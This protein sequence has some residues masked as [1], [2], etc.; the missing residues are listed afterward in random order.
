MTLAADALSALRAITSVCAA[1]AGRSNP[2]QC[3][4]GVALANQLRDLC[5]RP[6]ANADRNVSGSGPPSLRNL[7]IELL[8]QVIRH[9][10]V[11]SLARLASTCRQLYFGP[12]CPPWPTSV[13]EEELRRRAAAAGK[14]LPSSPP[15]GASRW[16]PALLQREWRD[17]LQ[18]CTVAAG[19]SPHSLF[20]D[21]NGALVVCGFEEELGTLGLPR[22]QGANQSHQFCTVLLP[23]PVPSM[24]GIRIWQVVASY[25]CSLALSEAVGY[26]CGGRVCG[27]DLRRTRKTGLC[28][29]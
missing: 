11:R 12:P 16:V 5:S 24:A 26:T 6:T 23:T 18:L 9:L 10:D 27:G 25:T 7:P 29:H 15:A 14:W 19:E 28:R 1:N 8:L 21:A 13:V 22:G 17:S 4:D 20:V 3:A 2:E